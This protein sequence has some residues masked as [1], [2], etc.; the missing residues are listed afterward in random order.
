MNKATENGR[1][2]AARKRQLA[3]EDEAERQALEAKLLADLG[4]PA[5]AIERAVIEQIAARMVRARRLRANG[6]DDSEQSRLI[7]Q[8]VRSIKLAPP[9]TPEVQESLSDY[10][11]RTAKEGAR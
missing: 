8:L 11:A 7:A 9:A 3:V 4:H 5:N 1:R 6:R 2:G 10:L